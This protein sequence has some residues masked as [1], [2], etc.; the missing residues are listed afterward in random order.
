M[1]ASTFLFLGVGTR[2]T[3]EFL[4]HFVNEH[5]TIKTVITI[6]SWNKEK[7]KFNREIELI[8]LDFL[9]VNKG[10]YPNDIVEIYPADENLIKIFNN[11][12][13]EIFKI[14]D[15]AD[16]YSFYS[17]ESRSR[18]FLKHIEFW[19]SLIIGKKIDLVISTDMPHECQGL[20]CILFV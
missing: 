4:V 10:N 12:M 20:Y 13:F 15:R 11:K 6:V 2:L 18:L 8:E 9:E 16:V 5:T 3:K 14:M 17:Y 7:I 19:N 1:K